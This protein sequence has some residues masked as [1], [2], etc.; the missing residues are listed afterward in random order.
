MNV[1]GNT[2]TRAEVITKNQGWITM[3]GKTQ[4]LPTEQ[5]A[6]IHEGMEAEKVATTLLP[7]SAPVYRL[8]SLGESVVADRPAVGIQVSRNG[9]RDVLLYFDKEQGYLVKMQARVKAMGREVV[10][11]TIYSDYQNSD[12]I[13]NARKTTTKRD[14]KL[15]LEC[16][17]TEF[18]AVEEIPD[19]TF[20][21]PDSNNDNKGAAAT[22]SH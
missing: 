9:H 17:I 21:K 3:N 15:F 6:E 1:G 5:L 4:S 20:A 22:S 10:D 16:E 13:R 2:I 18:K 11:E 8:T 12:G 7:L 19:S 14:G